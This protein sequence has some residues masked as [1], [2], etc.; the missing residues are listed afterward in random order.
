MCVICN[1]NNDA[2]FAHCVRGS[3]IVK[4]FGGDFD[5]ILSEKGLAFREKA[6]DLTEQEFRALKQATAWEEAIQAQRN[7]QEHLASL[8]NAVPSNDLSEIC[9]E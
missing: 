7:F 6:K 5:E 4:Y 2:G 8:R 3:D 1:P 9:K